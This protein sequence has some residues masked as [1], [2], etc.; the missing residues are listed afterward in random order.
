M[1]A[2]TRANNLGG[3]HPARPRSTMMVSL[4][5]ALRGR[6]R[7]A[8]LSVLTVYRVALRSRAASDD[9]GCGAAHHRDAAKYV[10]RR[11]LKTSVLSSALSAVLIGGIAVAAE[12][13]TTAYRWSNVTVGGGGFAPGIV[14]SPAERGLAYLRTDMGGAY[15]WNATAKRWIPLEDGLATG[16]YQGVESVAPDP[17]DPNVVYLAAG[18]GARSEAAI[19][20][21]ADRGLHWTV[22][23]V[24]FA[25]GGNE[26][27][28]GLGERLAIDPHH[29]ATLLFGSR[30]DG[31]WR[32]D[33]AGARWSKV[34]AFPL[35]GL[36]LPQRRRETHAGL[37]FV[38]YDPHVA[39]RVFVASADPGA[40]HLF[41]SDDGARHWQAVA[42][43]PAADLLPVKAALGSDG[44]LTITYD[45]NIGPN[46]ITRGAVWR[47]DPTRRTWEDVTPDKRADAPVG[48]YMGVAVSSTNPRL[49]AVSTVDRSRPVDTVWRSADGGKHWDELWR[50]STRDVSA[51]PFLNLDGAE[52]NFGHWISGLAIDPFDDSHVAYTTGATMYDTH[53]FGVTGTMLWRPWT[54][55]IEQTAIITFTS[56][57]AGAPLV[58][59]FGDIG[60]FRHADLSVSPAHV[61]LDPYLTNTN[62][63][64][65]A[66]LKPAIMDRSGNTHARTVPDTSL[67]WSTDGGETWRPLRGAVSATVASGQPAP[68]TTGDAP[69]VVSADGATFVVGTNPA[70]LTRDHGQSWQ[71]VAGLAAGVRIVAD[72][73]D[74]RRFYAVDPGT[75]RVLRSDDAAASFHAVAARGLPSDLTSTA[76]RNRESANA[77]LATP[78]AAGALWL[79]VG[80]GLF[81]S[82]DAGETWTRAPG[83]LSVALYGLGRAAPGG[84]WPALYAVGGDGATTGLWRSTDG[85]TRWTRIN[86]DAHQWGLRFRIIGGDPKRFGRVYVGTDGRGILFGDPANAGPAR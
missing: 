44:V 40:S 64:D 6:P 81:R 74:P 5:A 2:T 39:G 83:T 56:P 50:R 7:D 42:G 58:S 57:T 63:L 12:E 11:P 77:L 73:G 86:D 76:P 51:S 13:P 19:L 34:A 3:A 85:G 75:G 16:S 47:L 45:D 54:R 26:D 9:I 67:A 72:K 38:L 23:P 24:P 48:G 52:P 15:R 65:F 30:H 71:P 80:D 68:E 21:S 28:R 59:G 78:G 22:V 41:R 37:S 70:V 18:V 33:D 60:G 62:T 79:K 8:L 82:T 55:G 14:F 84:R 61:H 32:S 49:I 43:G 53:A 10:R 1:N 35:A 66:G 36:G 69:I 25:M 46:G 29:T 27:G 17:V 31:L 4:N 20:R